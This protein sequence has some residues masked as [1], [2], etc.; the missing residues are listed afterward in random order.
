ME[1]E[2]MPKWPLYAKTNER[3]NMGRPRL[4]WLDEVNTDVRKM[5]IRM[6]WRKAVGREE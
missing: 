4:R 2:Q 6:Q 3:R 5:G 1:D